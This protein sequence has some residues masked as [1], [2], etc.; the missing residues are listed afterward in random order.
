MAL[1]LELQ[2]ALR[3]IIS[4]TEIDDILAKR[5]E[6]GTELFNR[7]GAKVGAL[8]LRLLSVGLKDI[9][10]PGDLK[11]MFVQL[12]QARKEGQ[13]ALERARGETAALRS[14]ANAAKMVEDNPMLLQL[15]LLQALGEGSGNSIVITA[16]P[17]SAPLPVPSRRREPEQR[18]G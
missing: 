11:K 1:H 3:E 4:S 12:V 7:T 13:A 16:S 15:R 8:G 5:Q 17:S 18:E 2:I 14:L 10:F 6:I 9:M